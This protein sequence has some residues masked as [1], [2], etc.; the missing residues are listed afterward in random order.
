MGKEFLVGVTGKRS[1]HSP[2]ARSGFLNQ[3]N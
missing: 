2:Q 1:Q 3:N